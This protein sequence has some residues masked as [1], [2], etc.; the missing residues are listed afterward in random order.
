MLGRVRFSIVA[1][2]LVVVASA[3]VPAPVAPTATATPAVPSF[4]AAPSATAAPSARRI[5]RPVAPYGGDP[6]ILL[7]ALPEAGTFASRS[8]QWRYDGV[9]GTLEQAPTID[10]PL[11]H[12]APSGTLV[13]IEHQGRTPGGYAI[14]NELAIR[15]GPGGPDRVVY[16]A[17]EL[18]YWSGWSPD[19]RYVAVWE[20]DF[21]SGS[22]DL[23]GRPLVIIEA[24]TGTRVTLGRTLLYGSTAWTPP[25]TMAFVAGFGRAV[26]DDKR[27]KSWSPENGIRD[28]TPE[29]IASYA[30]AWS[31]D[32]Q[33]LYFASGAAGEYDPLAVFA[34]QGVGDRRITVLNVATGAQRS[35]AHEPGYVE[36]SAR[37][38]RD[39]TRLLVLRRKT[40]VATEVRSIADA[41]FE[42]WLTDADGAQGTALVRIPKSF[43]YSGWDPGPPEWNWS[44]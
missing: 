25:H 40:V 12:P 9:H 16:R 13:A 38:S 14:S 23:D 32:G 10:E 26:W 43:G 5:T 30:P 17:P 1:T 41:P 11:E 31:G 33:S 15:D 27:L 34:G 21:Y 6:P 39:G 2:L 4:V 18:F 20:V 35:L 42:V 24:A 36:E 29:G 7:R 8:G 28:L 44:E 19:G 3:C 37:P 22:L